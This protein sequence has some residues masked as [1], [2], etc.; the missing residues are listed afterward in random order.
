MGPAGLKIG[1][2][3]IYGKYLSN[4]GGDF[5]SVLSALDNIYN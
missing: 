2:R 1:L 5:Y 3:K 4:Q